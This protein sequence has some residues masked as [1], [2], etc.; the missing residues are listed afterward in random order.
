MVGNNSGDKALSACGRDCGHGG[1][2]PWSAVSPGALWHAVR[3]A[4]SLCDGRG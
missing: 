3:G 2:R 4:A 1:L